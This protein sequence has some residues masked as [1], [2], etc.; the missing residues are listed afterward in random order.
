MLKC[1]IANILDSSL[2]C[3]TLPRLPP[4]MQRGT[5]GLVG[6][7]LT[8]IASRAPHLTPAPRAKRKIQRIVDVHRPLIAVPLGVS[9]G[10][11]RVQIVVALIARHT[12]RVTNIKHRKIVF[13]SHCD[14]EATH[15]VMSNAARGAPA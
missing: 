13:S 9:Q 10:F 12:M 6:L 1:K 2:A 7:Q 14:V 15:V 4:R 8:V 3:Q 11:Q 5:G